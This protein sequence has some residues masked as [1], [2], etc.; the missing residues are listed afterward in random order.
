MI[1]CD[2]NRV[3]ATPDTHS[4]LLG[5]GELHFAPVRVLLCLCWDVKPNRRNHMAVSERS[6]GITLRNLPARHFLI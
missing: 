5:G 3:T 2:C 6:L 4:T 1:T